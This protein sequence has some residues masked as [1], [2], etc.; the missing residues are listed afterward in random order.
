MDFDVPWMNKLKNKEKYCK[1]N[2]VTPCFSTVLFI[3]IIIII[4]VFISV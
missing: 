4:I 3:I 1:E 2:I